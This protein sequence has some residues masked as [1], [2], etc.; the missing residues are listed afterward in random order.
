[1]PTLAYWYDELPRELTRE[2][3]DKVSE[4]VKA[5]KEKAL[6][7]ELRQVKLDGHHTYSAYSEDVNDG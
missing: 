7:G 1:M 2:E 4:K 6:K 3:W 5:Q